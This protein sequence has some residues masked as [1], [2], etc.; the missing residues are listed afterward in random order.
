MSEIPTKS[1]EQRALPLPEESNEKLLPDSQHAEPLRSGEPDPELQSKIENVR[2]NIENSATQDNP[3]E[4]LIKSEELEYN[5]SKPVHVNQELK[6][7]TLRRELKQLRRKL[8]ASER[9]LSKVIHQ[10]VVT[11][12]SESASKSITRPSGL[13]GG[14]IVAFLGTSGYLYL[15]KHIGFTYN[16]F[17]FV[18]LFV[19]GFLV[20]LFI[21]FVVWVIAAKYR[22]VNS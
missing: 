14:G 7:I 10:P 8:P 11:K 3:F 1:H 22:H 15:A 2:I 6:D 20:G 13:L 12:V 17:L 21:E 19:V 16:Y 4:R 9:I 18:I 5:K